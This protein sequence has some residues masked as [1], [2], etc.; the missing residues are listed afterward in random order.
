MSTILCKAYDDAFGDNHNF[1]VRNGAK[2]AIKAS[3]DRKEFVEVIT[4]KK[5]S[6]ENFNEISEKFLKNFLPIHQIM[7]NFY[8]ENKLTELP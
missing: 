4:G 2:L 7:W 6:P 5:Y 8:K 1:M 3:S